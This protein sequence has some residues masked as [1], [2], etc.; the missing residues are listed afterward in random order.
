MGSW[1]LDRCRR[2]GCRI[3]QVRL[4]TNYGYCPPAD[5]VC[6]R[7][8]WCEVGVGEASVTQ[9]I[10]SNPRGTAVTEVVIA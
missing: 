7:R 6:G 3:R 1:I 4:R 8:S 9:S 10:L 2:R 5:L